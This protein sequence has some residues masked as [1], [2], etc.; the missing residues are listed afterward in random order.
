MTMV[1]RR[2]TEPADLHPA[3]RWSQGTE[4]GDADARMHKFVVR[5]RGRLPGPSVAHLAE[6]DVVEQEVRGVGGVAVVV[7]VEPE[8][9]RLPRIGRR[10]EGHL[11][12]G[13]RVGAG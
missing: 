5:R 4:G 3:A 11:R 2:S 13:S 9:D 1:T 7:V 12:P 10:V 8:D 6:R